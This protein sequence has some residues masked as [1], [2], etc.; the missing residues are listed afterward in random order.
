MIFDKFNIIQS[1]KLLKNKSLN[2]IFLIIMSEEI[3]EIVDKIKVLLENQPEK[4]EIEEVKVRSFSTCPECDASYNNGYFKVKTNQQVVIK[5]ETFHNM[6]AHL[7]YDTE[8]GATDKAVDELE[9]ENNTKDPRDQL[10]NTAIQAQIK[11]Y[12]LED[13]TEII[14]EIK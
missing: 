7:I 9:K 8:H 10:S 1:L 4:T 3:L 2:Y 6:E 11:K 13:L 12:S 14:R 5:Y